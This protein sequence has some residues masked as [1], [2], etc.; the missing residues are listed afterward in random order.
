MSEQELYTGA[1]RGQFRV[2]RLT[3]NSGVQMNVYC[4]IKEA[5]VFNFLSE[6]QYAIV[7]YSIEWWPAEEAAPQNGG[8]PR[9]FVP[10]NRP[11]ISKLYLRMK[12]SF[13]PKML[14]L[15]DAIINDFINTKMLTDAMT[16]NTYAQESAEQVASAATWRNLITSP[17]EFANAVHITM[18]ESGVDTPLTVVSEGIRFDYRRQG[19]PGDVRQAELKPS[20]FTKLRDCYTTLLNHIND[21]VANGN[22]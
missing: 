5:T 6:L 3:D 11:N 16:Y 4:R 21:E 8:S 17:F 12:T 18:L 15:E 14:Y 2:Q 22:F 20:P 9:P 10:N 19:L 7:S 1:D 13:T